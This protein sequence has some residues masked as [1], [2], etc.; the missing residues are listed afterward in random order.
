MAQR[1]PLCDAQSLHECDH[2][3]S[4]VCEGGVQ[5]GVELLLLVLKPYIIRPD[6]EMLPE[7]PC[8]RC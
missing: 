3:S 5:F 2:V 6:G 8:A 4:A 1:A 7:A